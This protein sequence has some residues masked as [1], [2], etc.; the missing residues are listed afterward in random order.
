[1]LNNNFISMIHKIH[2]ILLVS[3]LNLHGL[4]KAKAILVEEQQGY[5]LT[6]S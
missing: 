2:N 6:Y 1:M 4:F 5:C 3:L